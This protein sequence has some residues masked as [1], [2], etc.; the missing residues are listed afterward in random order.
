[1]E[2]AA[3]VD[4]GNGNGNPAAAAAAA[5]DAI[6]AMEASDAASAAVLLP[7]LPPAR[8]LL[9]PPLPRDED[10]AVLRECEDDESLFVPL[11]RPVVED[12]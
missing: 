4:D 2:L 5:I 1:M 8:R 6:C 11:S 3:D 7:L 10:S 12:E 9:L